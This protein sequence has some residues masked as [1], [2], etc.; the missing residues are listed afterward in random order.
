M[1]KNHA[2]GQGIF[3]G[4]LYI[5]L[6]FSACML[7]FPHISFSQEPEGPDETPEEMEF[8]S[9]FYAS[10]PSTWDESVFSDPKFSWNQALNNP[11]IYGVDAFYSHLPAGMYSSVDYRQINFEKITNHNLIDTKKYFQD[12]SCERCTL[13]NYVQG[14]VSVRFSSQGITHQNGDFVSIPGNYPSNTIFEVEK[15]RIV[16]SM[17][18]GEAVNIPKADSVMVLAP[19]GQY[20]LLEGKEFTGKLIFSG[21][22]ITVANG[23]SAVIDKVEIRSDLN[24]PA[25]VIFSGSPVYC[26]GTSNSVIFS[27]EKIEMSGFNTEYAFHKGNP[28]LSITSEEND[29]LAVNLNSGSI[30]I[31]KRE[32]LDP[33]VIFSN[34]NKPGALVATVQNGGGTIRLFEGGSKFRMAKSSER[35][36]FG[37]VPMEIGWGG[38]IAGWQGY[39]SGSKPEEAATM[40]IGNNNNFKV[41]S[42]FRYNDLRKQFTVKTGTEI[43]GY[44]PEQAMAYIYSAFDEIKN[45]QIDAKGNFNFIIR[46]GDAVVM[47][48]ENA[49]GIASSDRYVSLL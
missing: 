20:L 27:K 16:V 7:F 41:G 17:P 34:Q 30:T 18:S 10:D 8:D 4:F 47:K 32:G 11:Q 2:K 29:R 23:E 5:M 44:V 31:Q 19:E 26:K 1:K 13:N 21:G 15:D 49:A 35:K 40:I 6:L 9:N 46:E 42:N 37:S 36:R 43:E 25:C 39:Y 24:H 38:D 12:F 45:T 14:E 28:Y 3:A 22:E 33:L 48:E